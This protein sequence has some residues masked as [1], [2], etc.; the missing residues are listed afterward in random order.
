MNLQMNSKEPII[1]AFL[2]LIP[3]SKIKLS[4]LLSKISF[5]SRV[6]NNQPN[7]NY[8]LLILSLQLILRQS[9][10][11]TFKYYRQR[12]ITINQAEALDQEEIMMHSKCSYNSKIA[13]II[14]LLHSKRAATIFLFHYLQINRVTTRT[15]KIITIVP[16]VKNLSLQ[17]PL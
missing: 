9:N 7:T 5:R 8:L 14:Q 12:Q 13:S 11:T 6:D 1:L 17:R 3:S 4:T 15:G 10:L 16:V 2:V